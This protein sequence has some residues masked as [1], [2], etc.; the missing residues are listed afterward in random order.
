MFNHLKRIKTNE[1]LLEVKIAS[2]F[3]KNCKKLKK[4][5]LFQ[6]R[7]P[8]LQTSTHYKILA[9]TKLTQRY[10]TTPIFIAQQDQFIYF[11]VLYSLIWTSSRIVTFLIANT[12]SSQLTF[13]TF[14]HLHYL[15]FRLIPHSLNKEK[16]T[17]VKHKINT[18]LHIYTCV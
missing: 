17:N 15:Y 4:K 6:S 16:L 3:T 2:N 11:V 8:P 7:P 9:N 14:L 18:N 13:T 10:I 5:P 12:T 1:I